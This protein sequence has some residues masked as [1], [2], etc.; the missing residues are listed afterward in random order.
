[1]NSI[2]VLLNESQFLKTDID[3][4]GQAWKRILQLNDNFLSGKGQD[5]KKKCAQ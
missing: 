1:M 3:F 2:I 4:R 5:L